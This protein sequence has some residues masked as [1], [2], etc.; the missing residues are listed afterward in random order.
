LM[1]CFYQKITFRKLSLLLLIIL[2]RLVERI[3]LIEDYFRIH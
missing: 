3:D 2:Q 1:N